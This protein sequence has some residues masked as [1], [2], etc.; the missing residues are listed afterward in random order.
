MLTKSTKKSYH[1]SEHIGLLQLLNYCRLHDILDV[2][3]ASLPLLP[4][5]Q[6]EIRGLLVFLF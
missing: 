6:V 3:Q 2:G 5:V 1:L 4:L